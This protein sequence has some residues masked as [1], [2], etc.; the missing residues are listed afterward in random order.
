VAKAAWEQAM[1][2]YNGW[3]GTFAAMFIC[4]FQPIAISVELFWITPVSTLLLV[5]LSAA[6]LVRQITRW[7]LHTDSCTF[8]VLYAALLTL[9]LFFTPGISE[10]YFW[11]AAI[12]YTWGVALLMLLTGLLIRLHQPMKPVA[13]ILRT[14]LTACC[15]FIMGGMPYTLA[16]GATVGMALVLLWG[17]RRRS[18]ARLAYFVSFLAILAALIIVV[19]APGNAIRQARAGE[20]MH[21][22]AAI[23]YSI[24]ACLCCT[25]DWAGVQLI[26][27]AL[28]LIPLLWRT[29]QN[30]PVRFSNPGWFSLFTFG[31]LAA[32]FVPP[33]Y[34]TG[35]EGYQ[36]PRIVGSLY[37]FYGILVFFN[38]LYWA[39]WF[40][41]RGWP[42]A[43]SL[44]SRKGVHI[45]Q[46]IA[47]AMLVMW[48]AFGSGAVF[49]T[50]TL[51]AY[52][53]V[54]TGEAAV[55]HREMSTRGEKLLAAQTVEEA[56]QAVQPLSVQPPLFAAD[57]LIYQ[58]ETAMPGEMHVFYKLQELVEQYG[59]G[60]VPQSEWDA[61]RAWGDGEINFLQ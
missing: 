55:Y 47:C 15:A 32:S 30:C 24:E 43:E 8:A 46:A 56:R 49:A 33:I 4:S 27:L 26:G 14:V 59:P 29:L 9:L 28:L 17:L 7:I 42:A 57:V 50:P 21:P 48:G 58:T 23:V 51:G 2:D 5:C 19:I 39:G 22:I 20:S 25:A 31:I 37:M 41:Q 3:Q 18:P 6:Y 16:L 11:H 40:A 53:S 10:L 34:A 12:Q 1:I 35:P 52:K 13:F 45:C 61:L 54:L 44:P 38:L 60:Q 36:L